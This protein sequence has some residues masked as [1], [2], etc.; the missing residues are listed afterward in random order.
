MPFSYT[1][2]SR[3]WSLE[4]VWK[5]GENEWKWQNEKEREYES[6]RPELN[7]SN[8]EHRETLAKWTNRNV[9]NGKMQLTKSCRTGLCWTLNWCRLS[10]FLLARVE[11]IIESIWSWSKDGS[12]RCRGTILTTLSC[13][14][15]VVRTTDGESQIRSNYRTFSCQIHLSCE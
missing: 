13:S 1:A 5:N 15:L 6:S 9:W 8:G 4:P 14:V 7:G 2:A 12:I 10:T 3:N 11:H